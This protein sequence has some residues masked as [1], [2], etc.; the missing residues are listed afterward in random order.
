MGPRVLFV[1]HQKGVPSAY[2]KYNVIFFLFPFFVFPFW[3]SP[4][5]IPMKGS[6]ERRALLLRDRPPKNEDNLF[7]CTGHSVSPFFSDSLSE[8]VIKA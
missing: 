4:F 5:G 1:V 7:E 6:D 8:P 2:P 3:Y